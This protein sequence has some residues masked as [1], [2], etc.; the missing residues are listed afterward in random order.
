[1]LGRAGCLTAE[2]DGPYI[3]ADERVPFGAL[4]KAALRPA[5]WYPLGLGDIDE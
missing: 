3:F 2:R 1:V 4:A 5:K